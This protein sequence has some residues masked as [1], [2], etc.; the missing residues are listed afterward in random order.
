MGPVSKGSV[1]GNKYTDG[2]TEIRG[3]D[4]FPSYLIKGGSNRRLSQIRTVTS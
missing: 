3:T 2:D 1:L 4:P